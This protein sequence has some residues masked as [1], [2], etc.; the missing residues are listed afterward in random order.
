MAYKLCNLAKGTSVASVEPQLNCCADV[1]PN[2]KQLIR[3]RKTSFYTSVFK[4]TRYLK[5]GTESR[6]ANLE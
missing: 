6:T 4:K 5:K 3:K 2:L 1:T